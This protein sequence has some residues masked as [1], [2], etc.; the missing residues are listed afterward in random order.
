MKPQECFDNAM[1]D[2]GQGFAIMKQMNCTV[3]D[4][5]G[6][7]RNMHSAMIQFVTDVIIPELE[8]ANQETTDELGGSD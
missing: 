2:I 7:V 5:R 3:D 4:Y 1:A 6:I 8:A